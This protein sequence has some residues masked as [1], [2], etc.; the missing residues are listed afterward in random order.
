M[1]VLIAEDSESVRFALR[2]AVESLGH[3]VVGTVSNG[4]QVLEQY[5][6]KHP[7]LVLMDVLMPELDGLACTSLL[8]QRDP[9]SRVLI[10]TGTR[11]TEEDARQAGAKGYLTKP[12]ALVELGHLLHAVVAA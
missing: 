3:E 2:L 1:R 5:G 9:Q 4:Q 12:F 10:V 7:D 11:Y 6:Q 8:A